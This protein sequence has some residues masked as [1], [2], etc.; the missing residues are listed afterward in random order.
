MGTA[1]NASVA[2]QAEHRTCNAGV[3][4]S[5]LTGG[6]TKFDFYLNFCYNII[7]KDKKNNKN[8]GETLV[9]ILFPFFFQNNISK[10]LTKTKNFD[11]IIIE[12]K[13]K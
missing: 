2:Q 1:S 7:R 5:I 3:V 11:I 12:T 10:M 8:V 4:S 9:K 13:K 6:S